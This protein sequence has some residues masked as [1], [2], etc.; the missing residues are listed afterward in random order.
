MHAGIRV[1]LSRVR[2]AGDL[3]VIYSSY[4]H[5]MKLRRPYSQRLFLKGWKDG[6]WHPARLL[7]LERRRYKKSLMDLHLCHFVQ[8]GKTRTIRKNGRALNVQDL[9][10][11][12]MELNIP[13]TVRDDGP[14]TVKK[15]SRTRRLRKYELIAVLWDLQF[16]S[17]ST[18]SS[19]SP[20][21]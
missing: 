21:P 3:R 2:R 15:A 10:S 7:Q 18:S 5:L 12:A 16:A 13:T 17:T 8:T 20:D 11:L 4:D 6:Q 19:N 14:A 9:R 1:A